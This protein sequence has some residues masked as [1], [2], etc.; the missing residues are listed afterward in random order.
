M[1]ETIH[2][3]ILAYIRGFAP[4]TPPWLGATLEQERIASGLQPN[5]GPEVGRLLGL[6]TRL[7]GARRVLEFGTSL[8]YSTLWL[9]EALQTT[10]GRLTSVERDPLLLERARQNIAAAGHGSR[11]DFVLGDARAVAE[12]L[13]GPF[14]LILQDSDKALYPELLERTIALTRRHGILAA[15]DA[16]FQPMGVPEKFSHPIHRYN[17]LVF[18]DPRLYSM[19]LPI[20][21]G[22]TLSVKLQN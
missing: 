3:S 8:G 15:D 12:A 14:D 1:L 11:V 17:E 5:I 4:G 10:G 2:P 13:V 19:T 21:D 6:L 22:L 18:A 16:L 20:G 9:A 7:I